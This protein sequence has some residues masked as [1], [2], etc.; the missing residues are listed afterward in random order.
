MLYL[1]YGFHF[2]CFST[3][4]FVKYIGKP[5]K[6]LTLRQNIFFH[7]IVFPVYNTRCILSDGM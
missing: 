3:F 5:N 4:N 6:Y 2:R 1:R 7:E